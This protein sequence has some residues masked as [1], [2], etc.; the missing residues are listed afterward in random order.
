LAELL[1]DCLRRGDLAVTVK[2]VEAA[3]RD[4]DWLADAVLRQTFAEMDT[5]HQPMSDQLRA[6][7]QRALLRPPVT[8]GRGRDKYDDWA[9]NIGICALIASAC[10][11]FGVRPTRS[12]SA[13]RSHPSG[14][15]LV[16]AALVR[17]RINLD[18]RTIQDKI[19]LGLPGALV[20]SA[21][22]EILIPQ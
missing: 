6:F 8:R 2:A 14:C 9:R 17:N 3:E 21:L 7:G 12:R 16:A 18:E 4:G 19:W 11:E 5:N 13:R 15:S 22:G 10:F 1:S 20:R